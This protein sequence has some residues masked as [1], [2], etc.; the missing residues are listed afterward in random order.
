MDTKMK[1]FQIIKTDENIKIF[2][3]VFQISEFNP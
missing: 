2:N 1:S 3:Q